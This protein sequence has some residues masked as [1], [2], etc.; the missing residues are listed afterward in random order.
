MSGQVPDGYQVVRKVASC[1]ACSS[2]SVHCL[3]P[4]CGFL[5]LNMYECD[6][7]CFNFTNSHI[8]KH[9]HRVHS[10]TR[11]KS[12]QDSEA[13]VSGSAQVDSDDN[14]FHYPEPKE[15]SGIAH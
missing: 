13:G 4:E 1:L 5:C 14:F 8:C 12:A 9:I 7:R 11:E 3:A 15:P 6:S 2:E 10:L